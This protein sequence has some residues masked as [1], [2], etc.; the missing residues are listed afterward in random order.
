MRKRVYQGSPPWSWVLCEERP[1]SPFFAPRSSSISSTHRIPEVH[2]RL[3][4]VRINAL[5]VK[6]VAEVFLEELQLALRSCVHGHKLHAARPAWEACLSSS[7]SRPCMTY[8]SG[9]TW[10]SKLAGAWLTCALGAMIRTGSLWIA[11]AELALAEELAP[12]EER[13]FIASI[14]VTQGI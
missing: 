1:P 5:V 11:R 2:N 9:R 6:Q 13:C 7:S 14:V 4:R 10:M 8:E 3:I 12:I